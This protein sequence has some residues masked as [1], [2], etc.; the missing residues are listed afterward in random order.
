MKL[1]RAITAAL[2]F[3][4]AFWLLVQLLSLRLG[5]LN[6]FSFA[7]ARFGFQGYDYFS[8]PRAWIN[9]TNGLSAY[10]TFLDP[11][12]PQATW[13]L[14]HPA[15]AVWLGSV[16][17]MLS[18]WTSYGVFTLLSIALMAACAWLLARETPD[19]LLH[20]GFYLLLLGAFPGY[21]MLYFGN[22]QPLLVLALTLI[23][24]GLL[25]LAQDKPGTNLVFAGLLLSL[26]TKPIVF[27]LLPLFLLLR[28]TRRRTALA[29]AIY[30]TVS[31]LFEFLPALNPQA[32]P[33]RDVL[34][35]ALHPH[36]VQ[37]NMNV[38]TNGMRLTPPMLDNSIHWLNLIAQSGTR[39]NHIDVMSLPVFL[40]DAFRTHTPAWLYLLPTLSVL[41][42]TMLIARLPPSRERLRLALLLACAASTAFFLTY[43]TVWEYQ[44]TVL[45]PVAAVL[46]LLPPESF[47]NA[48]LRRACQLL[49]LCAWLP[50][51]FFVLG[52]TQVPER[53]FALI[54]LDRVVPTTLLFFCLVAV[55]AL[56]LRNAKSVQP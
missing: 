47:P 49:A 26:F 16:L 39:M 50:T 4:T 22:V 34:W 20:R 5:W 54:R 8:L 55:L 52:T 27:L 35:L 42:L 23:F 2:P 51:L 12:G 9:L 38:Y 40:D 19:P 32:I 36:W 44:Y 7:A 21:F 41:V 29:L 37:Q 10:N 3:V 14:S 28:E 53:D 6:R 45:L 46:L 11:Y 17:S 43:N 33:F 1:R 30:A 18:P 13:Y 48:A 24:V 25:R 31:A 15:L 56:Q